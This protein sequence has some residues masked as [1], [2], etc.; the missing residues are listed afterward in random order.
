[1]RGSFTDEVLFDLKNPFEDNKI[2]VPKNN[3]S[4]IYIKGLFFSSKRPVY[5]QDLLKC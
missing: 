5:S 4:S 3:V 1:M 2:L